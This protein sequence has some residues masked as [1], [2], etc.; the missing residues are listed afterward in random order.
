MSRDIS[1][2]QRLDRGWTRMQ[3]M[4][5]YALSENEYERVL[6]S[7]QNIRKEAKK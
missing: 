3:L 2:G 7:L 1:F 4:D 5:Y 6:A